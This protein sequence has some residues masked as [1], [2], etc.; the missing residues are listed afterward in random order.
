MIFGDY[1]QFH[2]ES[3]EKMAGESQSTEKSVNPHQVKIDGV[4]LK[5]TNNFKM[6]MCEVMDALTTSNF[7]D[8]TIERK[9]GGDF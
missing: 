7:E 3:I 4:K 2:S 9:A 8:T 1:L 5:G 6:W